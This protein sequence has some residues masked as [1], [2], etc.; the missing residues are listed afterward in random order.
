MVVTTET[1]KCE[2]GSAFALEPRVRRVIGNSGNKQENG[3][4]T[5]DNSPGGIF[6][7]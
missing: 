5:L 3:H 6:R 4:E 1:E 2:V 7:P